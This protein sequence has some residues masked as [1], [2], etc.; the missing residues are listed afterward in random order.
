M[1]IF[2][3]PKAILTSLF[4]LSVAVHAGEQKTVVLTTTEPTDSRWSVSA[5][6]TVSSIKTQFRASVNLAPALLN[7]ALGGSPNIYAGGASP[8]VYQDGSVGIPGTTDPGNGTTGFT[9]GTETLVQNG[10][11]G[12]SLTQATF[13][14][15]TGGLNPFSGDSDTEASVGPYIKLA[16][17]IKQWDECS[18]STFAQYTFTT[19]FDSGMPSGSAGV[20]NH[21]ISYDVYHGDLPVTVDGAAVYNA[22]AFNNGLVNGAGL[23]SALPPRDQT[24]QLFFVGFEPESMNIYLH[25]F[26]LGI[27]FTTDLTS[28]IHVV[29]STGPTLNLFDYDFSTP[30]IAIVNG[31][32]FQLGAPESRSGQKFRWGWM[33]RTGINVDLDSRKLYFAELSGEYHMIE[34]FDVQTNFGSA[35]VQASSW[36]VNIGLGRR[37]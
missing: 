15:A 3:I 21:T 2:T 37:F 5:G 24:S 32:P 33:V 8:E 25:T 17:L 7:A 11:F 28:R 13:H 14:S 36:G 34:K 10:L 9:G 20:T 26:T 35:T 22:A 18:L 23:R 1:K 4:L 19:A 27:D 6:V 12:Y 29:T 30:G 16:Y 31:V